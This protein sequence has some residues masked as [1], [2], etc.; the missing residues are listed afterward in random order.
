MQGK[1]LADGILRAEDGNRYKFDIKDIENLSQD[2][3]NLTGLEVDFELIDGEAKSLYI[4]SNQAVSNPQ[5]NKS[6][7]INQEQEEPEIESK[8]VEIKAPKTSKK[9]K[10]FH[11]IVLDDIHSRDYE[12][13][14]NHTT[15]GGS[16]KPGLFGSA[17]V[18]LNTQTMQ[19]PLQM[20]TKTFHM[21][22]K[23][24]FVQNSAAQ[25]MADKFLGSNIT[26][27]Q[28]EPGD[29]ITIYA[30]RTK[31]V[32][33]TKTPNL[34]TAICYRNHRN[35]FI[36]GRKSIVAHF[37]FLPIWLV[38][39]VCFLIIELATVNNFVF[40]SCFLIFCIFVL[41]K[42]YLAAKAQIKFLEK[43]NPENIPKTQ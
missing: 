11:G 21:G 16:I 20:N 12:T 23:T 41:F 17:N 39:Y 4:T 43:F 26:G 5:S 40:S 24:F 8:C 7:F 29:E 18:N 25:T 36:Y 35:N 28:L 1:I 38:W 33:L 14:L 37:I 6:Q 9:I 34:Y 10:C 42:R 15:G 3:Q 32:L 19:L 22:D 27:N 13:T 31:S 30:E 2:G